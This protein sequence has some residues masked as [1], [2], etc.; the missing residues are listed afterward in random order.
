MYK[1]TGFTEKANKALNSA[2]ETAENLGHTYIGSEHLL[3]GL[4]K[5]GD[6]V[7]TSILTSK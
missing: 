1:F 3:A 4:I 7:A 2:V 6:S 5:D